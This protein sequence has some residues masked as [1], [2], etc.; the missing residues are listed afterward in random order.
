MK[1]KNDGR[2]EW[3]KENFLLLL[4]EQVIKKEEIC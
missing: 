4:F 1:G 3:E 2:N